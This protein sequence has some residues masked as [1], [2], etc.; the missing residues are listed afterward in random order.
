M[1]RAIIHSGPLTGLGSV[2]LERLPRAELE[3]LAVGGFVG[4]F[5]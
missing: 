1:A 4:V 3:V 2:L 5:I